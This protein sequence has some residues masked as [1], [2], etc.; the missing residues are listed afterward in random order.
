M[1]SLWSSSK[2]SLY[3][4]GSS[5]CICTI[6]SGAK[7]S[8]FLFQCSNIFFFGLLIVIFQFFD[9]DLYIATFYMTFTGTFFTA[10]FALLCL[11]LPKLWGLLNSYEEREE[12]DTAHSWRG[13]GS[14]RERQLRLGSTGYLLADGAV[15]GGGSGGSGGMAGLNGS[16]GGGLGSAGGNYASMQS[17]L[18]SAQNLGRM[19]DD[20]S[21]ASFPTA[22]STLISSQSP[23]LSPLLGNKGGSD[24]AATAAGVDPPDSVD[25]NPTSQSILPPMLTRATTTSQ[26]QGTQAKTRGRS[27]ALSFASSNHLDKD[28]SNSIE[29]RMSTKLAHKTSKVRPP[30]TTATDNIK[31]ST[32]IIGGKGRL[33]LPQ[34]ELVRRDFSEDM[35]LGGGGGYGSRKSQQRLQEE[36][37]GVTGQALIP[38]S[39]QEGALDIHTSPLSQNWG[40]GID[41]CVSVFGAVYLLLSVIRNHALTIV[42]LMKRGLQLSI[43]GFFCG[44]LPKPSFFF[45][46]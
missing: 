10:T 33:P 42:T 4:Q 31:V 19:P 38:L 21:F 8:S 37:D 36:G 3:V 34:P 13:R 43:D 39:L 20:L 23:K 45:P 11:F 26:E 2:M 5:I 41:R 22:S 17:S 29:L 30:S 6:S 24:D 28:N 40:S 25:V 32:S 12:S 16:C 18:F 27:D 7:K 15:G 46:R 1:K 35:N 14:S 9:E 44:K